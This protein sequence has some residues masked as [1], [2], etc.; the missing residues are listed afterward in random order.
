MCKLK[1][2]KNILFGIEYSFS[3]LLTIEKILLFISENYN[4]FTFL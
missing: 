1:Y 2:V 4:I 3:K